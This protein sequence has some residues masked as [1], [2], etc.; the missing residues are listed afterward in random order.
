MLLLKFLE[1]CVHLEAMIY[2]VCA[3]YIS[4][5]MY[6][7]I[8]VHTHMPEEKV[9]FRISLYGDYL[10]CDIYSRVTFTRSSTAMYMYMYVLC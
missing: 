3:L 1:Y 9:H 4:R 7:Y 5:Y 8:H 2:I 10:H 6:M